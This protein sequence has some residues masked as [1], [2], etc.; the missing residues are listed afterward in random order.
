MTA[1]LSGVLVTGGS[2]GGSKAHAANTMTDTPPRSKVP[3]S[4]AAPAGDVAAINFSRDVG[5]GGTLALEIQRAGE[6]TVFATFNDDGS[7][8]IG[9]WRAPVPAATFD[10]LLALL[11]ASGY[12]RAPPPAPAP[13]GT[14]MISLGERRGSDAMPALRAFAAPAPAALAPVIGALQ[15]IRRDLRAHPVRVVRG[16]A[17]VRGAAIAR[18]D[19][20]VI[21]ASLSNAGSSPLTLGNPLAIAR[22]WNGLRLAFTP[23]PASGGEQQRDLTAVDLHADANTPR[24]STVA[25]APGQTLRFEVRAKIDLPAKAYAVRLEYHG[26]AP[27]DGG[28]PH[29][30]N[31]V[32]FLPAGALAIERKAWWKV[33]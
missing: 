33:W 2:P 10:A 16:Q 24:T 20:L 12:D 31:G 13:P 6:S 27:G 19:E 17:V 18:G 21:A 22:G 25:L 28:D 1:A 9:V 32:L 29:L 30:V 15:A 5:W 3:T 11:H 8:E 7:P 4:A 14:K 23:S 26:M